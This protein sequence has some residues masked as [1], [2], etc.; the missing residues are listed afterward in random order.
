[1]E[2][3]R[4][5]LRQPLVR[6]IALGA[7]GLWAE[8]EGDLVA[9]EG[10][11]ERSFAHARQAHTQDALSA[12]ASQVFALRRR[13]GRLGELRQVV[14]RLAASG[15]HRLGWASALGVL[16]LETGDREGARAVYE[17]EM[18]D[19]PGALARGM[20]RL[21]RLSLL[22][23]LCA[24]LGDRDGARALHALL[25]PHAGRNVVVAY[26]SFWGPV[27]ASLALL[28]RTLGDEALARRHARAALERTRAM[29]APAFCISSAWRV[30]S[31]SGWTSRPR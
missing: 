13:Q 18:S 25:A 20:F 27:D 6:S 28:A 19:G 23:E 29:P 21:T 24:G 1:M 8:L 9:A 10:H 26:C 4:P 31:S 14:E 11:A 2:P 3:G 22:S 16:R 30:I 15:G 5:E 12:W 17:Q 7:R